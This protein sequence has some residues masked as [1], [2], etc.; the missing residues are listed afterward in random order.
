MSRLASMGTVLKMKAS[1]DTTFAQVPDLKE[2]PSF[3]GEAEKVETTCIED[4]QKTYAPGQSDPGDMAFKFA[5]T[6]MTAGTNWAK[7]R[8]LQTGNASASFQVVFPDKS[9]F[10]WDAKVSLSM[11]EIGDGNSP[12]TFTAKM[13]PEGEILPINEVGTGSGI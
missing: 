1:G 10:Q 7:L 3:M 5:F 4:T 2:I 11:D 6:G 9:G 8:A 13:F 12:L